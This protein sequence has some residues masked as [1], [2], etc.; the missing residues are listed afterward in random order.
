MLGP[1][2]AP[3]Q[4]ERAGGGGHPRKAG[5]NDH[6]NNCSPELAVR[7][8]RRLMPLPIHNEDHGRFVVP[9]LVR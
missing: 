1:C 2:V 6:L 8:M 3:E 4:Q 9:T 7:G 5:W